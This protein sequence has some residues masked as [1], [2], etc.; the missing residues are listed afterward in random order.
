MNDN[1]ISMIWNKILLFFKWIWKI[2]VFLFK[3]FFTFLDS[4]RMVFLIPLLS[5]ATTV[6]TILIVVI[7]QPLITQLPGFLSEGFVHSLIGAII[8]I[9]L[10]QLIFNDRVNKN[11]SFDTKE[12]LISFAGSLI[13]WAGPILLLKRQGAFLGDFFTDEFIDFMSAFDSFSTLIYIFLFLPH[14]WLAAITKEFA[15]SVCLGLIINGGIFT[16]IASMSVMDLGENPKTKDS[17]LKNDDN[18]I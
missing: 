13:I 9:I 15:F 10:A 7:F 6:F 17:I 12:Y 16:V 4:I 18:N 5:I 14:F 8:F 3:G 1:V 2:F 11:L